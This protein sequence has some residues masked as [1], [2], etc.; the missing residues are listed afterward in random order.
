MKYYNTIHIVFVNQDSS[1]TKVT[2][3]ALEGLDSILSSGGISL[4]DIMS[5][6]ALRHTNLAC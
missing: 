3:W 6:S 5:S 4:F 1:V 2:R